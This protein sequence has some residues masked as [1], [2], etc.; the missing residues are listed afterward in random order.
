[1]STLQ[2]PPYQCALLAAQAALHR[3]FALSDGERSTPP[4]R[5]GE[6]RSVAAL[7]GCDARIAFT[8]SQCATSVLNSALWM[9]AKLRR[10]DS[11]QVGGLFKCDAPRVQNERTAAACA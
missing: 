11:T 2:S 4:G 10:E 5:P 9:R 1:M 7:T 6:A 8:S 3:A